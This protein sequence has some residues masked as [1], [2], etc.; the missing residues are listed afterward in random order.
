MVQIGFNLVKLAYRLIPA[1]LLQTT[2]PPKNNYLMIKITHLIDSLSSFVLFFLFFERFDFFL[3]SIF[4][5]DLAKLFFVLYD[6]KRFLSA[7]LFL[8]TRNLC[9]D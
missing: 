1:L 9:V 3:H 8:K 7:M 2:P 4:S 6:Q 5:L